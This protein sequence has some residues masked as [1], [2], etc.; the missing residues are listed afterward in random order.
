LTAKSNFERQ[1]TNLWV[2]NINAGSKGEVFMADL[3]VL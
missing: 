3:T 1:G 2:A